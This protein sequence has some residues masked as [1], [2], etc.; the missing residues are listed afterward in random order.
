MDPGRITQRKRSKKKMAKWRTGAR[1]TATV[2]MAASKQRVADCGGVSRQEQQC[3][4]ESEVAASLRRQ[5]FQQALG[6]RRRDGTWTAMKDK[7][8]KY[9]SQYAR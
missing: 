8:R 4:G 3:R 5:C 9:G 6:T 7:Q 1:L 2:A